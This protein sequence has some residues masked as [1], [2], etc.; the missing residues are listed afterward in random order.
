MPVIYVRGKEG[1]LSRT[2]VRGKPIPYDTFVPVVTNKYIDRLI[3]NG[4]IEVEKTPTPTARKPKADAVPPP[5]LPV[6]TPPTTE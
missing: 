3:A 2:S 1:R 6:A 5:A 4:D